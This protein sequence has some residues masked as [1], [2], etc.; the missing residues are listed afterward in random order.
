LGSS[1][2]ITVWGGANDFLNAGVTDPTIP[3]NNLA[4]EITTLANAGGKLFMVPNLPLLGDIP[5]TN[6]LPQPERDALNALSVGFDSLLQNELNTLQHS[7]GIT[8]Y[9]PN[10]AALF[11]NVLANPSAYG[12]TN[13]TD[14][15]LYSGDPTQPGYLF[16]D[17]VHPTTQAGQFIADVAF[18]S[19]VPEPSALTLVLIAAPAALLAMRRTVSNQNTRSSAQG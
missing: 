2:L 13:V 3:V 5:A 9:Q 11:E 12:F 1:K 19:T 15:L 6:T 10:I 17:N 16:W 14:A 18:A 4:S 7:L 8:I